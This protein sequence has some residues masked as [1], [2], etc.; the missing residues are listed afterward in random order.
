MK[1]LLAIGDSHTF[2][3]EIIGEGR[4]YDEENIQY[5]YPQKLGDILEF[6]NVVN[7]GKSGGS[8]MRT[9]RKLFEYFVSN[10][11]HPDLVVLGWTTLGRFEYCTEIDENGNYEYAVLTSWYDPTQTDDH[12]R[13]RY[14]HILPIVTADDLLAQ[15]YKSMF[16][17]QV[18]CE[19]YNV[20]YIMFDVMGNTRNAAALS[21]D[22]NVKL[23]D[24]TNKIDQ[25][26]LNN[27]NHN[28]YL[29]D[30]YWSYIMTPNHLQQG[31][32][33]SGGHSNEVGHTF[34][35][36]KLKTE[37]KERNIYGV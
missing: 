30:D 1:T 26:F 37:L 19:R 18:L 6:D 16:L 25:Y 22:D 12:D 13:E 3:A 33:M 34:W 8:N 5:A 28:N 20:P 24:G 17:C 9:E 35:A 21:G 2:G 32:Q 27:I 15:K 36:Q 7:L 4:L 29:E 11:S 31:V 10:N 14:K 23:W